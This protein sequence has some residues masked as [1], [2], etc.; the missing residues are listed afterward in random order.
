M[1]GSVTLK[2]IVVRSSIEFLEPVSGKSCRLYK[3]QLGSNGLMDCVYCA[4]DQLDEK[5][6]L[7]CLEFLVIILH[8]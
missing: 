8:Q 5:N 1:T 7:F 3:L 6:C 4:R 2:F